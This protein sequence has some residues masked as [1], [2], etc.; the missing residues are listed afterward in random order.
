MQSICALNNKYDVDRS[1]RGGAALK[2]EKKGFEKQ[3]FE[4]QRE[5][6]RKDRLFY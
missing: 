3:A 6:W 2:Q 1:M 5:F 4:N